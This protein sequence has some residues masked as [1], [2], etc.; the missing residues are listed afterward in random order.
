[1]NPLYIVMEGCGDFKLLIILFFA[2]LRFTFVSRKLLF[3]YNKLIWGF[4]LSR[5]FS[6]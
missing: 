4:I 6:L 2:A 1:M 3:F 5:T